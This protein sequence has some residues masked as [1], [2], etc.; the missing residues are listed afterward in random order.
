MLFLVQAAPP[1]QQAAPASQT[2]SQTPTETPAPASAS[3][4]EAQA[5]TDVVVI[6]ERPG[7]DPAAQT[8]SALEL[9]DKVPSVSVD[10]SGRL[11][12]LGQPGV[13]LL[14]DGQKP[15]NDATTLRTLTGSN[16]DRIEVMTNPGVQYGPVGTGGIINIIT[17]HQTAPGVTGTIST[18]FDSAGTVSLN[19][20]PSRTV[21]RWTTSGS[22]GLS[23][24]NLDERSRA[25]R[26]VFPAPGV[27][28]SH[29]EETRTGRQRN[30]SVS[31]KAKI[32]YRIDDDRRLS[33]GL[34]AYGSDQDN[35]NQGRFVSADLPANDHLERT[36]GTSRFHTGV[37]SA[38]YSR[39]GPRDG[40]ELTLDGQ[41]N[42]FTFDQDVLLDSDYGPGAPGNSRFRTWD[43]SRYDTESLKLDYKRPLSDGRILTAGASWERSGQT[44]E[45]GLEVISGAFAPVG[46]T[47][48]DLDSAQNVSAVYGTFQFE[49][50]GFTVLPG[51]RLEYQDLALSSTTARGGSHGLD[52]YPSLHISRD[53]R[54]G[55]KLNLSY[56]RRINRPEG[57]NLDPTVTYYRTGE[58]YRGN[59]DLKPQTT[60]S[61]EARL[62]LTRPGYSFVA[63]AYDRENHDLWTGFRQR[64][65][66]GVILNTTINAGDS[67]DRGVE[68]SAR[69]K[70]GARL[71]YVTT[72]NLFA[73]TLQVLDADGS[74]GAAAGDRTFFA[75]GG[76]GQL[77]Y[78]FRP[79]AG[80]EA[81]KVQLA[82]NYTGPRHLL[83][84]D[85]DATITA[86]LTWR[87]PVT[88]K[89]AAVLVVRN[90]FNSSAGLTRIATPEFSE[91]SRYDNLGLQVR[92]G[93]SYRLGVAP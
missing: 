82:V 43:A 28:G 60:D 79:R 25:V 41:F 3:Q 1:A 83:Q 11:R 32:D 30:P 66:D 72:T 27:P 70:I 16:I 68:L 58:A 55:L 51:L 57:E 64:L 42:L 52:L 44:V 23:V 12:L 67:A 5:V 14:I 56:A 31:A 39:T 53:L 77:E 71:S 85:Y 47:S 13:T 91:I 35:G 78:A 73:Q 90:L 10:L 21:G 75:W 45:D 65:D 26:E 69:G 18:S 4:D 74:G 40:E 50:S 76:N 34:E 38:N 7:K 81:D 17:R 29:T 59:A 36:N 46:P 19:L 2:S 9:L 54:E 48:R 37:L 86:N 80:L 6:A 15:A 8:S 63:V 62:E 93:L 24:Q 92:F 87:H 22:F 89:I 61:F 49:R 20:S 88:K 33:F 84:D